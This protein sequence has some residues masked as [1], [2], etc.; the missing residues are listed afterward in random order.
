LFHDKFQYS[1][2]VD[3][4]PMKQISSLVERKVSRPFS[5]QI[6]YTN[7]Y[8]WCKSSVSHLFIRAW[9]HVQSIYV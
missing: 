7:C 2:V 4:L 3:R 5:A 6:I 8:S 9:L 1:F